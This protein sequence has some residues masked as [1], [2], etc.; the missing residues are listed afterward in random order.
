MVV[1]RVISDT[2]TCFFLKPSFQSAYLMLSWCECERSTEF[3]IYLGHFRGSRLGRRSLFARLLGYSLGGWLA[4]YRASEICIAHHD[5]DWWK[6]VIETH[7]PRNRREEESSG[8]PAAAGLAAISSTARKLTPLPHH[9][10]GFRHSSHPR[11]SVS[12]S[13]SATPYVS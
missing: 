6:D 1:S 7:E 13:A 2:P 3:W 11:Q 5:G 12:F 9:G 4:L 8:S 10:Q